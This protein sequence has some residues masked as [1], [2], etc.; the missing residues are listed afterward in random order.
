MITILVSAA[1]HSS[2]NVK[3]GLE[4]STC[5]AAICVFK[6]ASKL[7]NELMPAVLEES[8]KTEV[9]RKRLYQVNFHTTLKGE[10]MVGA[11]L[12]NTA[13]IPGYSR[14]GVSIYASQSIGL[15]SVGIAVKVLFLTSAA[16]TTHT[17]Y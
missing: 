17:S 2:I 6:V 15:L 13:D 12:S 3:H 16:H 4:Y 9:L 8:K 7:I 10:A 1:W 14:F 11:D 5:P